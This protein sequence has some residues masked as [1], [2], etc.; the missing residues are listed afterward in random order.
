MPE[1]NVRLQAHKILKITPHSLVGA[2]APPVAVLLEIFNFLK[3][4]QFSHALSLHFFLKLP[5]NM[6]HFQTRNTFHTVQ[7]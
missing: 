3:G 2:S 5:K 6:F 1:P 7:Y 4:K